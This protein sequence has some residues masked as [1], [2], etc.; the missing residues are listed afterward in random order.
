MS[1][2][3]W[4]FK[5]TVAK[6]LAQAAQEMGLTISG[7]KFNPSDG[8]LIVETLPAKPAVEGGRPNSFD[9]VLAK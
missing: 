2:A 9:Q 5:L 6:R 1:K 3:S 4:P 7:L 8:S